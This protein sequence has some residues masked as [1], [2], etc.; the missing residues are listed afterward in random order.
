MV[1]LVSNYNF[2]KD[3]CPAIQVLI[4]LPGSEGLDPGHCLPLQAGI[5]TAVTGSISCWL[6]IFCI[7]Y[8]NST[9]SKSDGQGSPGDTVFLRMDEIPYIYE[10]WPET[11]GENGEVFVWLPSVHDYCKGVNI[12]LVLLIVPLTWVNSLQQ[13]VSLSFEQGLTGNP[14]QLI[15]SMIGACGIEDQALWLPAGI[16][17]W[18]VVDLCFGAICWWLLV[19]IPQSR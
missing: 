12:F 2:S 18:K 8:H 9:G 7:F 17:S 5:W 11:Y 4:S 19:T 3:C 6:L 13:N 15:L 14:P 16:A 1:L 10:D